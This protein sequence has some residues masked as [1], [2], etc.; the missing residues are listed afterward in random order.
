MITADSLPQLLDQLGFSKGSP[1]RTLTL[2][3]DVTVNINTAEKRIEYPRLIKI[4]AEQILN[5]NK[6]ENF[7]V[8]E[9]V[10]RLLRKGYKPEHIELEPRWQV[11]HGGSG[12]RADILVYDQ[13]TKPLL[14]IECKTA[15]SEFKKEWNNTLNGTGQLFSYAQQISD[16]Q[17]L[18]LYASDLGECAPTYSNYIIAHIDNE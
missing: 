9:C 1:T 6:N 17:F 14:L 15:G 18:C 2:D 11:G 3:D 16:V 4:R 12:G 8:L 13:S 7:V 10:V 5:F